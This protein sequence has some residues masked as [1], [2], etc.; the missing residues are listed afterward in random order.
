MYEC[1]TLKEYLDVFY[2]QFKPA[3]TEHRIEHMIGV[4]YTACA[5]A[6]VLAQ[7]ELEIHLYVL[8]NSR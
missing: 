1:N 6:V 5:A 4:S 2:N 7:Y 3:L 8:E